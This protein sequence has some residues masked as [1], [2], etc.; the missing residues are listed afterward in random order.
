MTVQT[1]TRGQAM[2]MLHD[3]LGEDVY[4]GLWT[5]GDGTDVT[6][7]GQVE[8]L[9]MRGTLG[10]RQSP[11]DLAGAPALPDRTRETFGY[12]YTVGDRH[13]VLAPLPG[14]ITEGGNGL[15]FELTEGLRLR[16]AWKAPDDRGGAS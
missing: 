11:D 13:I 8:V 9:S 14:T 10:H 2:M 4:V 12:L 7:A 1:I 15:N 5:G 3:H 6:L 16:I